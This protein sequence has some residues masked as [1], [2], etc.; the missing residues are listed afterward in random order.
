MSNENKNECCKCKELT[1]KVVAGAKDNEK[2]AKMIRNLR[3]E[4][5]SAVE[6]QHRCSGS[7]GSHSGT[8][9]GDKGYKE[10]FQALVEIN[11]GWKKDYEELQMR[12]EMLKGEKRLLEEEE[13]ELKLRISELEKRQ[14][15]L[16]SELA[17]L[18]GNGRPSEEQ[19]EILKSQVIVY[20]EDFERERN[21][22]EKLH[23]EKEKYKHK[24][25]DSEK[26]IRK[27]TAELDVCKARQESENGYLSE[28]VATSPRYQVHYTYP[29]QPVDQRWR[30][31]QKK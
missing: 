13:K 28:R 3:Q 12:Y 15:P 5:E 22:R 16:E 18:V 17:R 2:L 24:L 9:G 4:L 30:M 23:E 8:T 29:Y 7:S 14:E 25:D 11:H 19:C 6:L 1:E 31:E 21:D 20:K 10:K 26:T 27:L